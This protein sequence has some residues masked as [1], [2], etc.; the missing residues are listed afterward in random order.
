VGS[1]SPNLPTHERQQKALQLD[2]EQSDECSR[3][4]GKTSPV[5]WYDA[6]KQEGHYMVATDDDATAANLFDPQRA[7]VV[8]HMMPQLPSSL[9]NA[10]KALETAHKR[11][12]EEFGKYL[13]EKLRKEGP[14]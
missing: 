5:T 4:P 12:K 3:L 2:K 14:V 1:V 7:S 10:Y 11:Y 6:Q 9:Q 8:S 13:Y